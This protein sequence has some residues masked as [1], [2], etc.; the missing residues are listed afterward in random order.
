MSLV[1]LQ[2]PRTTRRAKH[3]YHATRPTADSRA[4]SHR[5][6]HP[7]EAVYPALPALAR[8]SACPLKL[9]KTGKKLVFPHTTQVIIRDIDPPQG[10]PITVQLYK[11]HG[12]S[13]TTATMA[14]S[15][16]YVA[17]GDN[18][19]NLRIWACD[20]PD[21]IMK[22]ETV[23]FSGPILDVA[24][25]AD[26]QRLIGVGAGANMFGKVIM[27]DS[28]NS[29]GEIGGHTKQINSCA[30]KPT[31]PFRI[32]TGGEEGKV[33]YYEG[34]PFKFKATPKTHERFVNTVR[35]SPDGARFFS[36]SSDMSIAVYDGKEGTLIVEKKV[37]AR[38]HGR[39]CGRCARSAVR[40]S[41]EGR[42]G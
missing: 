21:Q 3:V 34:P 25:S 38:C 30:F 40:G 6:S 4:D 1:R 37:R 9:D 5:V 39:R 41:D 31:R 27:W 42:V 10:K 22:L 20:N 18:K 36:S 17:S 23:L 13:V 2:A 8:G 29:V 11:E 14:P 35:F 12:Y 19:G 15:G 26:S 32:V 28:G 16:C 33:N 7:Q 24:W